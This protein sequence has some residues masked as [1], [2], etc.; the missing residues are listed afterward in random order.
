MTQMRLIDLLDR[1]I[2][3]MESRYRIFSKTNPVRISKSINGKVGP[4]EN[5]LGEL[6]FLMN[7]RILF[8]LIRKTR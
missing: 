7:M 8:L 6:L 1:C 2:N 4:D 3:E 5:F